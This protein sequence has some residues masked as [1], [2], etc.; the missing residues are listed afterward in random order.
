MHPK[1]SII[2]PVYKAEFY[3]CKC[4][5]SILY[6]SYGDWEA[7][8]IDDGSPDGSGRICDKYAIIDSRFKI[9]HKENGGVSSARNLGLDNAKGEWILYVDSDDWIAKDALMTLSEYVGKYNTDTIIFGMQNVSS[10]GELLDN[11]AKV[12]KVGDADIVFECFD[13]G[14]PSVLQKKIIIDRFNLRFS[15]GIRMY[16]DLELQY[17]FLMACRHAVQIPNILYYVQR[18]EGSAVN[19]P[20]SIQNAAED[21]P[22]VLLH[23]VDFIKEYDIKEKPWIACRLNRTF[24]AAMSMNY[25]AGN[26]N[27]EELQKSI[28]GADKILRSLGYYQYKDSAVKIGC[29]DVRL[30]FMYQNIRKIFKH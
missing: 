17:K 2:V 8:L 24:K 22:H 29:L 1:F 11:D 19:N 5:D 16:E 13:Y 23:I 28:I 18:H 26:L 10:S 30:Y 4:L 15:K 9:F 20:K 25:L 6:Q 14:P 27:I 12:F 21:L 7:L 3:I